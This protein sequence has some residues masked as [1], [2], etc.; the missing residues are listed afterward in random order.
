MFGIGVAE[1]AVLTMFLG[2]FGLPLG[3][4][5]APENPAM[6][7]VAPEKCLYY[8]TWAGMAAA[9]GQSANQT[10][11]LF[12]EPEVQEFARAIEKGISQWAQHIATQ[13]RDP[14]AEL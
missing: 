13:N 2:G 8:S 6:Q 10:E 3:V 5:P 7:Y 14:K 9:D 12:A 4:P 11:Q 1:V